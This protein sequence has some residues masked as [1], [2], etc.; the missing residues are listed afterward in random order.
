MASNHNGCPGGSQVTFDAKQDKTYRM[1][2]DG[3]NGKQ[4][5]FTLRVIDK[6]S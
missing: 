5:A 4:G 3:Y 6:R 2:V 1:L